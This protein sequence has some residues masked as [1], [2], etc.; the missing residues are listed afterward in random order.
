MCATGTNS[1]PDTSSSAASLG[2]T[3]WWNPILAASAARCSS[4]GT[5][6]TSPASPTSPI[7][8]TAASTGRSL[9]EEGG[10][11]VG[12]LT[13]P[14][15]P[16]L[17]HADLVGGPEA[18]FRRA[19]DAVCV[20]PVALKVQ[21]GIHDVFQHAGSGQLA[22]LGDVAHDEHAHVAALRHAHQ[23]CRTLPHLT[24]ASRRRREIR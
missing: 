12:D 19:D 6:R 7:A 2:T 18:V 17:E 9:G 3:H 10:R 4:C 24:D 23:V 11:R 5:T 8:T 14:I 16:H 1:I 20:V 15:G 13:Q 21:D 22:F